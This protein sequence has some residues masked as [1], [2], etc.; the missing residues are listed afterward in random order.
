MRKPLLQDVTSCAAVVNCHCYLAGQTQAPGA[1]R[2]NH[3]AHPPLADP[4]S[5][6]ERSMPSKAS[7]GNAAG[8]HGRHW[9]RSSMIAVYDK[10]QSASKLRLPAGVNREDASLFAVP[11]QPSVPEV[12]SGQHD[13]VLPAST[14]AFDNYPTPSRDQAQPDKASASQQDMAASRSAYHHQTTPSSTALSQHNVSGGDRSGSQAHDSDKTQSQQPLSS[15]FASAPDAAEARHEHAQ[16]A[17][18]YRDP[19]WQIQGPFPK[20]DILDWF[21]AGFFPADLPIRHAGNPHADFKPL[22]AQIKVWAAAAPPGFAQPAAAAAAATPTPAQRTPAPTDQHQPAQQQPQAEQ[23]LSGHTQ[24]INQGG[25]QSA[26]VIDRTYTLTSATSYPQAAV[27]P[28]TA[29]SA[30][31]DALETGLNFNSSAAQSG[32]THHAEQ[33]QQQQASSQS[34]TPD[35]IMQLL[36]ASSTP[37]PAQS[38]ALSGLQGL[39]GDPLA[40]FSGRQ[41]AAP[42]LNSWGLPGGQAASSRLPSGNDSSAGLF[43][44][45]GMQSAPQQQALPSSLFP[46]GANQVGHQAPHSQHAPTSDVFAQLLGSQQQAR[47]AQTAQN[48]PQQSMPIPTWVSLLLA[49]K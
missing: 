2:W 47:P 24:S 7:S 49:C 31:L 9:P 18:V 48:L 39:G 21:E 26:N 44:R 34:G 46:V 35:I 28:K 16:D 13:K 17:W 1:D 25:R 32:H 6:E 41:S 8:T 12:L 4:A 3:Q 11:G 15:P 19:N 27:G 43:G 37:S 42:S 29:S 36:N 10:L 30:K 22:A 33:Q 14:S 45:H 38:G 5:P 20:A 23:H 40:H